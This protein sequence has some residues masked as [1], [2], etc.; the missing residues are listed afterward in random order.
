[1][2]QETWKLILIEGIGETL[3]MTLAASFIA[4]LIGIPIGVILVVTEKDGIAPH[5]KFQIILGTIVNLI[6]SVPF[7]IMILLAMPLTRFITGTTLGSKAMIVP[8][9][10]AAAPY[11]GRV[12]ESSLREVDTGVI[13]AAKSMG[14][15]KWQIIYKVILPEAKPALLVGAALSVTTIL[16]YSAMAGI[17]G[18][19]GLGA[20]AINYGYYRGNEAMLWI[21]VI[22]IVVIFQILQE[23][24]MKLA[25]I[26]DKRIR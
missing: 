7:L 19:G 15:S 2:D 24:G 10:I 5:P 11:V 21:N 12:V 3:Y 23:G 18:A 26:V 6:R 9:A 4:Y 13:E 17:V 8:L 1:M 14:A 16:G 25:K 20:F 22:L